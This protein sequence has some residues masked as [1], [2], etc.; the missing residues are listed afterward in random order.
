MG[1]EGTWGRG[2]TRSWPIYILLILFAALMCGAINQPSLSEYFSVTE[3]VTSPVSALYRSLFLH[4][5]STVQ[6]FSVTEKT[7]FEWL[8]IAL[9]PLAATFLHTTLQ[10][11]IN[12]FSSSL[13]LYPF[14]THCNQL[15]HPER[16]DSVE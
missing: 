10:H 13:S 16:E 2:A 7:N 4:T 9:S 8:W 3:H 11:T 14:S 5:Q 1:Y 15:S 6:D 12:T